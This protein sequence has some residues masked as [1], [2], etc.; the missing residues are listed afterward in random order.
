MKKLLPTKKDE[1]A[2]LA[3]VLSHNG[4]EVERLDEDLDDITLNK[5]R[6]KAKKRVNPAAFISGGADRSCAFILP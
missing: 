6:A 1:I 5:A 3:A 2:L 4:E